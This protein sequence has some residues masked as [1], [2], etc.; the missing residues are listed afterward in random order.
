M[1]RTINASAAQQRCVRCVNNGIGCAVGDVTLR[2]LQ[3]I[4]KNSPLYLG[5]LLDLLYV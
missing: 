1:D 2:D 5:D 4:H 3:S